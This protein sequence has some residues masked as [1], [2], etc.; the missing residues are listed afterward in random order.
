MQKPLKKTLLTLDYFISTKL[1]IKNGST[2]EYMT[3]K[4]DLCNM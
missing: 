2:D 4:N 1:Y 3:G